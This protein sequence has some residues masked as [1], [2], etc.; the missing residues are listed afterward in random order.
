MLFS[1]LR[2]TFNIMT[3][4]TEIYRECIVQSSAIIIRSNFSRY[5]IR[6]C[7]NSG[8]KWVRYQNHNRHPIY[9]PHGQA[10]GYV[11]CEFWRKLTV[12]YRHCTVKFILG[13]VWFVWSISHKVCP[14]CVDFLLCCGYMIVH[15]GFIWY[16]CPYT[17]TERLSGWQPW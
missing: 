10:M 7:D 1:F 16:I 11:L 2:S 13:R 17:E 8:R 4:L 9:R 14:M 5:Y 15:H 12:L 3:R 6:H